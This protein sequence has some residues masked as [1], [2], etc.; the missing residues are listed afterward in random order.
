ML[1]EFLDSNVDFLL[2]GDYAMA[3][4]ATQCD[5]RKRTVVRRRV[6]AKEFGSKSWQFNGKDNKLIEIVANRFIKFGSMLQSDRTGW[7]SAMS[8]Q[9]LLLHNDGNRSLTHPR[10]A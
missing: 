1:S 8:R 9:T 3:A 2:I 4:L 6:R 10:L 7:L 5:D